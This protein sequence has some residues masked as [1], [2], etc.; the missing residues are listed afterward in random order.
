MIAS[1]PAMA[2]N[3]LSDPRFAADLADRVERYVGTIRDKATTPLVHL[4][5]AAV[6]GLLA[7]F[8][9]VTALV[10]F[11]IGATRGLQSLL[12]LAVDKPQAVYLS[13][14]I[15]GGILCLAGLLVLRMRR[16]GDA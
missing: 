12:D 10:L 1:L 16:T 5:R 8:L 13:Y 3:P 11:V 15:V 14:L 2:G 9:G 7:G 4:A 6:Y